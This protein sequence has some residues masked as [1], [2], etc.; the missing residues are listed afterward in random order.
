MD[1]TKLITTGK[2]SKVVTVGD[3]EFHLET[4]SADVAMQTTSNDNLGLVSLMTV[5][6]VDKA[7]TAPEKREKDYRT[8]EA[9]QELIKELKAAQGGLVSWLA[10]RC[11]EIAEEQQSN[12]EGISKK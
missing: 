6:V 5:K 8:S 4:P 11:A 12:I 10:D 3:Y 7:E 9:K 1:L 2:T